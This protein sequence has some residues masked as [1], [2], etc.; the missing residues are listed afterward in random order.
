ME[1]K[2]L[3]LEIS[4]FDL[5]LIILENQRLSHWF[6]TWAIWVMEACVYFREAA[7]TRLQALKLVGGAIRSISHWFQR[8]RFGWG[9]FFEGACN[10]MG[11]LLAQPLITSIWGCHFE[12]AC[13]FSGA[14]LT[15]QNPPQSCRHLQKAPQTACSP[16]KLAWGYFA[17]PLPANLMG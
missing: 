17:L 13:N 9:S 6:T 16:F 1:K 14:L 8:L 15:L 10:S 4:R 12:G 3:E 11:S 5:T 2:E 7:L